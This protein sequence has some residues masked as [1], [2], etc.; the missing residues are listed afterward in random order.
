MIRK[1][2]SHQELTFFLASLTM[3]LFFVVLALQ[4]SNYHDNLVSSYDAEYDRYQNERYREGI[5]GDDAISTARDENLAA[6]IG[7]YPS[8]YEGVN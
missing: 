2:I 3:V 7:N 6:S 1:Q 4:G 5:F 8:A